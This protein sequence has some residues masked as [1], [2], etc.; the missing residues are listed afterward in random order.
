M[1]VEKHEEITIWWQRQRLKWCLCKPRDAKEWQAP[2][3]VRKRQRIL[4]RVSEGTEICWYLEFRHL[5]SKTIKIYQFWIVMEAVGNQ[6]HFPN[7]PEP[8]SFFSLCKMSYLYHW[9]AFIMFY[10]LS[11]LLLSLIPGCTHLRLGTFSMIIKWVNLSENVLWT[12]KLQYNSRVILCLLIWTLSHSIIR[13]VH[14]YQVPITECQAWLQVKLDTMHGVYKQSK[15]SCR[16]KQSAVMENNWG[17]L[18]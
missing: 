12:A 9:Y 3:E 14:I 18:L 6:Y 7:A 2:L 5:V 10:L 13:S 16:I 8:L 11:E 4:F 1:Q 15:S 17:H